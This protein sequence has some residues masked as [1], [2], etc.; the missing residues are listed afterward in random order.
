[1]SLVHSPRI[2]T[3]EL[4]LYYDMNNIQK[5]WK[6]A[7]TSNLVINNG[8][9]SNW[10]N[11]GAGTWNS[12]DI[13]IDRLYKEYEVL[14]LTVTTTGNLHVSCSRAN[15]LG[16][17]VYTVSIYCLIPGSAGTLVGS[18]PYIRTDPANASR[19]N[20]SYNGITDWN[21]W[22]RD[23][24][25]R[26]SGTF[27]NTANDTA[28]YISCYLN[29]LGNKIY[30]TGAVVENVS[31]MTPFVGGSGTSRNSNQVL[32]DLTGKNTLTTNSLT[33]ISDN[34]F[35]FNGSNYISLPNPLVQT[36]LLQKWTVSAWVNITS[37]TNQYLI[38][39]INAGLML[40]T[41]NATL[42][43]LNSGANDYYMY[44]SSIIGLGWVNITFRFDNALGL[45]TIY[46]N[47]VNISTSG[48]NNTST[49]SGIQSTIN[50]GTGAEGSI[51]SIMIYDRYLTDIEVKNNFEA[52]RGR[53]GV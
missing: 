21:N 7:P 11:S 51:S 19:G 35:S 39:N 27:T 18:I 5:S 36:N 4:Q 2:V 15:I 14:S 9:Y 10:A 37:K 50:I 52:F 12:N 43:Y 29:T 16:A 25:I 26:I 42:L 13:S 46:K 6:G 49:P 23:V 45:R 47:G 33:Y 28:C 40:N 38:S 1:M 53:Y 3:H 31:F 34:T 32:K 8:F 24:W 30:M 48:P 17:Q 41:T 20:L 22:P 44:G